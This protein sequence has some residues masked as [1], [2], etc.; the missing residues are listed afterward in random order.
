MFA[1]SVRGAAAA[2]AFLAFCSASAADENKLFI[3]QDNTLAGALGNT[4]FVDQSAADGSTVMGVPD[5]I[6]LNNTGPT[7]I[8]P[9]SLPALQRGSGNAATVELSG[10]FSIGMLSQVGNDNAAVIDVSG[11]GSTGAVRQVG[12]RNEGEVNVTGNS[13]TGILIQ[14]GS[15]NR[16]ALN[17]TNANVVWTQNGSNIVQDGGSAEAVSPS[18]VSNGGTVIVTQTS[19]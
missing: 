2:T 17:V 8:D 16:Q 18:V 11:N 13:L 4:L 14:N 9:A 5:D 10:A 15:D 1:H 12:H 3:T 6:L 7:A 19:R